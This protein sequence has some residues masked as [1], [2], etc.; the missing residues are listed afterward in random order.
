[1]GRIN[2]RYSAELKL[3]VINIYKEG[4]KSLQDL[5]DEFKISSKTQ[6]YCWIKKYEKEGAEAFKYEKRGNPKSK[7]RIKEVK[8]LD[9]SSLEEEVRFLRLENEY[10]KNLCDYLKMNND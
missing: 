10:L 2:K 1:M 9:F 3:S 7:K 4:G 5:A 8:K 6:I